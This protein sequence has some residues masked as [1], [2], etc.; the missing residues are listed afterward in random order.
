MSPAVAEVT[1][2]P[3]ALLHHSPLL[4]PQLR[5]CGR[6]RRLAARKDSKNVVATAIARELAGFLWAEM[7]A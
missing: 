6:F 2:T 4:D 1:S 7:A 5:L 3:A